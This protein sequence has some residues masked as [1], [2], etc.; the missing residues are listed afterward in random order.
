MFALNF[1]L[2][3][4]EEKGIFIYFFP[5]LFQLPSCTALSNTVT[6][7]VVSSV[8][9]PSEE[10]GLK[11]RDINYIQTDAAITFGNSG[12]PLVSTQ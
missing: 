9:R 12:G 10:L 11:G 1:C 7:G 2:L 3:I 8:Q 6:S 4:A 5:N